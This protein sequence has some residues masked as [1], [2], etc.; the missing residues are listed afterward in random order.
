MDQNQQTNGDKR[1]RSSEPAGGLIQDDD[2]I[3]LVDLLDNL[4]CYRIKR[5][6][7][8]LQLRGHRRLTQMQLTCSLSDRS[9]A[10]NSF[11]CSQLIERDTR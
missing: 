9:M 2:T 11:Q 3:S 7:Q 1:A 10:H 5:G 6:A 4:L 8:V